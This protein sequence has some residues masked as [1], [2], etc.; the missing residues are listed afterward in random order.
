[1]KEHEKSKR[2][3]H[4]RPL[5]GNW[6]LRYSSSVIFS[7]HKD[8]AILMILRLVPIN[9]KST[10]LF[11]P[12]AA[13]GGVFHPLCKIRSRHP[14]KLKFTGLTA[15]VTFYKI[16]KFESSTII[17]DVITK[18]NGKIRHLTKT[19]IKFDPD[20]QEISNMGR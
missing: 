17:N 2:V 14:R 20:N 19:S 15:Y 6:F 12:G 11:P 1:M 9:P 3:S 8:T 16:R 5:C 10:V 18:N 7:L 4:H 13:L